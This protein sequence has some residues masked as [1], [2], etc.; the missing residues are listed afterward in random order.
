MLAEFGSGAYKLSLVLHLLTVIVGFGALVA[1]GVFGARAASHGDR[2][3]PVIFDYVVSSR[4][5]EWVIYA[6]PVFG[7]TTLLLSDD[8]WKFS[9]T[10]IS[11]SFVLYIAIVGVY[12]GAHRPN[13]VRMNQLM[14]ELPAGA[15]TG[16]AVPPQATELEARGQK[17]GLFGGILNLLLVVVVVLMVWK[18]GV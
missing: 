17:A 6:V 8:A 14:K 5:A 3:G 16:G 10:W 7:I 13:L 1:M 11:I 18:P 15:A 9:Q 12:H 4:W 2:E